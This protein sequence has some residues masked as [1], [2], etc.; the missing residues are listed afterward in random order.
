[1]T[2]RDRLLPLATVCFDKPTSIPGCSV[3]ITTV[4]AKTRLLPA[5]DQY[6]TPQPFLDPENGNV[7]MEHSGETR[8]YPSHRVHYYVRASAALSKDPPPFE[9]DYTVGPRAG[10]EPKRIVVSVSAPA[11]AGLAKSDKGN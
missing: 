10:R 7:V 2:P 4:T 1:M 6:V 5:G 11:R 9:H 3:M 8:I